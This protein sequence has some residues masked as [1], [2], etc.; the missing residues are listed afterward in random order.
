MVGVCDGDGV[1]GSGGGAGGLRGNMWWLVVVMGVDPQ[2]EDVVVV[3]IRSTKIVL[4]CWCGDCGRGLWM[5]MFCCGSLILVA[6]YGDVM[7]GCVNHSLLAV[8]ILS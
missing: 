7:T 3:D 1:C 6:E 5:V 8:M 4:S 2:G